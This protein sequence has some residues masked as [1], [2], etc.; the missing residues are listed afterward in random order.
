MSLTKAQTQRTKSGRGQSRRLAVMSPAA[1]AAP[2][3]P[4]PRAH[5]PAAASIP[6]LHPTASSRGKQGSETN[7]STCSSTAF[8]R[9]YKAVLNQ[10]RALDAGYAKGLSIWGIQP[11]QLKGPDI[12]GQAPSIWQL[13]KKSLATS[14][15]NLPSQKGLTPTPKGPQ[16]P[17]PLLAL[18]LSVPVLCAAARHRA[19]GARRAGS[20]SSDAASLSSLVCLLAQEKHQ[21]NTHTLFAGCHGIPWHSTI[22]FVFKLVLCHPWKPLK[23]P[24][25]GYL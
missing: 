12:R 7:P 17:L 22:C 10:P 3:A 15:E 2:A 20:R 18:P 16:V 11:R 4:L 19:L 1:N 9:K 25:E 21:G 23:N 8:C 5:L 6:S 24:P 13:R 14:R